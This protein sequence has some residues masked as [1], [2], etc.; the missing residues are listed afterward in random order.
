MRVGNRAKR[1]VA[2]EPAGL[3][4][5]VTLQPVAGRE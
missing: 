1:M 2:I 4:D 3:I 5:M